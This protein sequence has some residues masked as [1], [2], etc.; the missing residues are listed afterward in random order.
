MAPRTGTPDA[1]RDVPL[2]PRPVRWRDLAIVAVLALAV[3][4]LLGAQVAGPV[5]PDGFYHA[6]IAA[7]YGQG[8]FPQFFPWMA[9]SVFA[10][11]FVDAQ[12]GLH[13]LTAPFTWLGGDT[14]P[15][16]AAAVAFSVLLSVATCAVSVR[17]GVPR[18]LAIAFAA[19]L[20][21]ASIHLGVRLMGLRAT[22]L[23]I[24]LVLGLVPLL[25]SRRRVG[26]FLVCLVGTWLYHGF[27]VLPGIVALFFVLEWA[28]GRRPSWTL[29]AVAL[30]GVAAGLLANPAFP[31]N[32]V[33]HVH[34]WVNQFTG[35][36]AEVPISQEWQ[37]V[38]TIVFLRF[39]G[40]VLA[41]LVAA[42][43]WR[44]RRLDRVD[45]FLLWLVASFLLASCF[46]NRF[47]EY[48]VPLVG[49]AA[50]RIAADPRV[51]PAAAWRRRKGFGTVLILLVLG[52]LGF[53]AQGIV[54][55]A[56]SAHA[57]TLAAEA[58]DVAGWLAAHSGEGELVTAEWD[59]FSMLFFHNNRNRYVVGL[60]PAYLYRR[61]VVQY[62][63]Y[64]LL[65]QNR[66]RDP[67]NV[68]DGLGSDWLLV[69]TRRSETGR[70]FADRLAASPH[71]RQRYEN[72]AFSLFQRVQVGLPLPAG[73]E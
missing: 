4:G 46:Y 23:M 41:G 64:T 2:I 32:V 63:R 51:P 31:A 59:D 16:R 67:E 50:L 42:L 7:M 72:A 66:I 52:T 43:A 27:L 38:S 39:A 29:P 28:S 26:V 18:G 48:L 56:R 54:Q 11:R 73:P 68:L 3:Q 45:R 17:L 15:M 71:F 21:L 60:N 20:P 12:F 34:E 13:L 61:D 58:A 22:P 10:Q 37:P 69:R 14:L 62:R 33:E 24:A 55:A 36:M 30:A 6:R 44:S 9:W 5:D 65:F 1:P 49:V 8:T 19:L 47:L 57:R 53:H 40:P 35:G 70:A 25:L